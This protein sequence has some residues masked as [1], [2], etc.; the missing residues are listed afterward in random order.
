MGNEI[1]RKKDS[2]GRFLPLDVDGWVDVGMIV[3]AGF[4]LY[5]ILSRGC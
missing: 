3:S 2:S 4:M 5:H 1:E